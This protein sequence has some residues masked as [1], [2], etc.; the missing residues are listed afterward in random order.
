M[1]TASELREIMPYAGARADVYCGP[2][3]ITCDEFAINTA[4]RQAAFIAQVAQESGSLK[5]VRELASGVAYEGRSDLGNTEPGDGVKFKGWGLM[6]ITGRKNTRLVSLAL[7]G[8]ERLITD[9]EM[10]IAP[11]DPLLAARAAGYFWQ[12]GAG[13]NL[14]QHAHDHGVQNGCD[15]NDLADADDFTGITLAVN[16]G[17]NGLAA[18]TAFWRIAKAILV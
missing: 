6:Q 11:P 12:T 2:L 13:L 14:S 7:F 4:A 8:D 5:Y 10:L 18:R 17:L 3:N 9:S 16:G 1:I 15:L